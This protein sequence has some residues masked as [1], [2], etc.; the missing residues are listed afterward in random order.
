MI[1]SVHLVQCN[2][3]Y[4]NYVLKSLKDGKFYIGYTN[5]IKQRLRL[6]KEGKVVSTQYRL[7]Y[8][9]VYF[10]TCFDLKDAL[11]RE[12]YLKSTYGKRYLKNRLKNQ[13]NGKQL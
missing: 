1:Q 3:M 13:I 9:L 2:K 11:H 7:P 5:N 12:K 8:E 4:F 6:H 10:E